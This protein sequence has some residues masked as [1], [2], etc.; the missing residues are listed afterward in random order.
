M[1]FDYFYNLDGNATKD[2]INQL[3]LTLNVFYLVVDRRF[4]FIHV[5]FELQE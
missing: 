3:P 1:G 2:L 4:E 5:C